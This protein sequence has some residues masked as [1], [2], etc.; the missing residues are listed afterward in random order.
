MSFCE[1]KTVFILVSYG[2]KSCGRTSPIV[3]ALKVS[4]KMIRWRRDPVIK[5]WVAERPSAARISLEL[6]WTIRRRRGR[7]RIIRFCTSS[8][9]WVDSIAMYGCI[10]CSEVS[11]LL[12]GPDVLHASVISNAFAVS[13]FTHPAFAVV[14]GQSSSRRLAF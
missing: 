1:I 14:W 3:K 8:G 6:Q 11:L 9:A 4:A 13:G 12:V 5:S 10:I 2:R 7:K